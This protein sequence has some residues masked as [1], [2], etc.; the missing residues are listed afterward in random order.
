MAPDMALF[1]TQLSIAPD[2]NVSIFFCCIIAALS[3]SVNPGG[4]GSIPAGNIGA[5]SGRLSIPSLTFL[6]ER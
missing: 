1:V 4:R 2:M 6:L 3:S 5:T